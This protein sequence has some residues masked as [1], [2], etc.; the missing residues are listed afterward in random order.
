M[1]KEK[2]SQSLFVEVDELLLDD[3]QE[4]LKLTREQGWE[5]RLKRLDEVITREKKL[6][7]YDN[8][9]FAYPMTD[10]TYHQWRLWEDDNTK[11]INISLAPN[12]DI[13]LQNRGTRELRENE[14]TR[15]K[16]M[17]QEGYHC[18]KFADLIIDNSIQTPQE[19]L[20]KILVFLRK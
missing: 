7:R 6:Q 1:L 8:I 9:I 19:T 5:E 10:K 3:E 20:Q 11:F 2:L 18:S 15:I 17:Y 16:Q 13:C 12:I 14:K 4:K